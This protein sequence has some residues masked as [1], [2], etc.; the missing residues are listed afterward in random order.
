[1]QGNTETK[2]IEN[3]YI[4]SQNFDVRKLNSSLTNLQ[5]NP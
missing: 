5:N 4:K 3:G 2:G 1:M